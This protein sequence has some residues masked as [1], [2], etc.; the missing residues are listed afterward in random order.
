MALPAEGYETTGTM[1]G[2]QRSPGPMIGA[3]LV[4]VAA[5]ATIIV[6][7]QLGEFLLAG[8]QV[9]PFAILALLAYVG[10]RSQ[11]ATVFALLW[12]ALVLLGLAGA[13]ALFAFAALLA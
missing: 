13:S 6:S 10:V 4:S 11:V 12:L 7:G 5:F 8:F 1:T 9:V 3:A 2:R